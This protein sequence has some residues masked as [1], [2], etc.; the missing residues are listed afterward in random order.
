[1]RLQLFISDLRN[2]LIAFPHIIL[3][4]LRLP[5]R[6]IGNTICGF[7]NRRTSCSCWL[8]SLIWFL[9]SVA[10]LRRARCD[11]SETARVVVQPSTRPARPTRIS[12][13]LC[14]GARA[15][16]GTPTF[17][18][19]MRRKMIAEA[20]AV[21]ICEMTLSEYPYVPTYRDLIVRWW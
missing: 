12:S 13:C 10:A 5:Q 4:F 18:N 19:A 17:S 6:A 16:R 1:M 20:R 9:T 21:E 15:R 14:C 7:T 2:I 3:P 11:E 8:S